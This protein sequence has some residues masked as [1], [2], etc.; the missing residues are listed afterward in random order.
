[1]TSKE[2]DAAASEAP[3]ASPTGSAAGCEPP[4]R[5]WSKNAPDRWKLIWGNPTCPAVC[6]RKTQI[7]GEAWIKFSDDVIY[8]ANPPDPLV[9]DT[10][11][12]RKVKGGVPNLAD[13]MLWESPLPAHQEAMV[14]AWIWH[15]LDENLLSFSGDA[16]GG[17]LVPCASLVWE[18]VRALRRALDGFRTGEKSDP[19]FIRARRYQFH[20]L[21]IAIESLVWEGLGLREFVTA[22]D[23]I[24]HFK[25]SLRLLV[26]DGLTKIPD[27]DHDVNWDFFC[28]ED[29][30]DE[31]NDF[32]DQIKRTLHFALQLQWF[33]HGFLASFTLRFS[34]IGSNSL[35]GFPVD[36]DWMTKTGPTEISCVPSDATDQPVRLVQ[37]VSDPM[38]VTSGRDYKGY[39]EHFS[40]WPKSH[41]RVVAPWCYGGEVAPWCYSDRNRG[42]HVWPISEKDGQERRAKRMQEE[43][44]QMEEAE[45][46]MRPKMTQE[47]VGRVTRSMSAKAAARVKGTDREAAEQ[48]QNE[49]GKRK[50]AKAGRK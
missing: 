46:E 33:L 50:E 28:G 20:V 3:V 6:C 34:P 1:M 16:Q 42:K 36:R 11:A 48:R 30:D 5:P 13:W 29:S 26:D 32:C 10:F 35:W 8:Y 41:M 2:E 18:H 37:L 31:D 25:K 14:R 40:L 9:L 7:I 43:E 49:G 45:Q 44:E 12:W 4:E 17:E 27:R 23:L 39:E 15:Y 47:I 19:D 22:A 24:P 38:L 21:R